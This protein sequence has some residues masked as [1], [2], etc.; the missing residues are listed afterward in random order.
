VQGDAECHVIAAASILAKVTRDRMMLAY[1]KCTSEL[2]PYYCL[3]LG[4]R[5]QVC[6]PNLIVPISPIFLTLS[7]FSS[8]ENVLLLFV[9]CYQK[10]ARIWI[11]ST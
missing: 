7:A 9:F 10:V 3:L 5:Y 1:D 2:H 6:L 11:Q 8:P 4:S